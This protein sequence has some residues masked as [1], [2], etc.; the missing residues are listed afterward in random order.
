MPAGGGP[1]GS[2]AGGARRRGGTCWPGCWPAGPAGG[3]WNQPGP[4]ANP[5]TG[6]A[7]ATPAPLAPARTGR[8]T[9]TC[10]R[11]RSCPGWPPRPSCTRTAAIPR[12]AGNGQRPVT[13]S[14]QAADLIDPLQAAD[15]TLIYDP[16]TRALPAS[17]GSPAWKTSPIWPPPKASSPRQRSR[18]RVNDLQALARRGQ[19]Q[20]R[21]RWRRARPRAVRP[22][23]AAAGVD[24]PGRRAVSSATSATARTRGPC[25]AVIHSAVMTW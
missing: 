5:P 12:R 21:S 11:T 17:T 6:A 22:Y 18:Q 14:A 2:R 23:R 13:A 10:A 16:A 1:P 24:H 3:G 7:P 19:G 25:P 9:C 15:V 4:T 20:C 8:R